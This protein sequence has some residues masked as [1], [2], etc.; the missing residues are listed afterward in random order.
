MIKENNK[1]I[2][3]DKATSLIKQLAEYFEHDWFLDQK[4]Q[5]I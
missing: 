4:I 1:R 3:A 5:S 2:Q